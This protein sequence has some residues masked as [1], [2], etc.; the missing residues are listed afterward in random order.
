MLFLSF[1]SLLER[2]SFR[3]P[4]WPTHFLCSPGWPPIQDSHALASLEFKI[5]GL[6]LQ[7]QATMPG[8]NRRFSLRDWMLMT[9][10]RKDSSP[11]SEEGLTLSFTYWLT[12]YEVSVIMTLQRCLCLDLWNLWTCVTWQRRIDL[13]RWNSDC[14]LAYLRTLSWIISH[15]QEVLKTGL[16]CNSPPFWVWEPP[17][18]LNCLE[19]YLF[20]MPLWC[21]PFYKR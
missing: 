3:Q 7:L 21:S 17:G 14:Y 8:L 16:C 2:V 18:L 15:N 13:C 20:L 11:R 10:Q 1:F 6:G 9:S 4:D 12:L 5:T 19:Y